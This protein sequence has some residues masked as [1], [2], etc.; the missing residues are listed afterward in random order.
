ME[1]RDRGRVGRKI[2]PGDPR[3]NI[4]SASG[5]YIK[6][7][8]APRKIPSRRLA[9]F[10]ADEWRKV[11]EENSDLYGN[12]RTWESLKATSGYLNSVFLHPASGRVYTEAEVYKLMEDFMAAARTGH[13]VV[14]AGQSAFM[15][16]TG[17]WGRGKQRRE[18]YVMGQESQHYVMGDYSGFRMGQDHDGFRMGNSDYRMGS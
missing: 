13:V 14:K 8:P 18:D 11:A 1:D 10:F 17:W 4:H 7:R 3:V 15:R 12:T 5:R 9:D 6:R 16:F 2:T